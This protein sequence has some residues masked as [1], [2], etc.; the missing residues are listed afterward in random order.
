MAFKL[1][2]TKGGY[3]TQLANKIINPNQPIYSL[4]I[5]LEPQQRFEDN[6][7]TG[8][9]IAYKAWF[10]QEGQDPFQVKFEESIKLPAFLSMIQFDSLQ[11]CEVKYNVYFKAKSIKEV[12]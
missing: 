3:T 9:I 1:K 5:E 10:V 4:S 2:S 8:E 11:A 6:K 12:R 7:P